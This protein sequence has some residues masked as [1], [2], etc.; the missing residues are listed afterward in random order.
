VG[1]NGPPRD[2]AVDADACWY[3]NDDD[4]RIAERT[5]CGKLTGYGVNAIQHRESDAM[6]AKSRFQPPL[7]W[8]RG[9]A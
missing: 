8:K 5:G 6:I 4:E 9:L 7:F 2:F 3:A 1:L